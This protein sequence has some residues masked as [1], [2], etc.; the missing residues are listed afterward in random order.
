MGQVLHTVAVLGHVHWARARLSRSLQTVA[1]GGPGHEVLA[2]FARGISRGSPTIPDEANRSVAHGCRGH[3]IRRD[4]QCSR[5]DRWGP[6][7]VVHARSLEL[8]TASR[9]HQPSR[10]VCR[11]DGVNRRTEGAV[12]THWCERPSPSRRQPS[13]D[14]HREQLCLRKSPHDAGTPQAEDSTGRDG[15]TDP[16]R[17]ASVRHEQVRGWVVETIPVWRPPDPAAA[18]AFRSGWNEGAVRRFSVSTPRRASVL[19]THGD[20]SGD[21]LPL[22]QGRSAA[23]VPA[24][25]PD[26]RSRIEAQDDASPGDLVDTGLAAP[27]MASSSAA[28]SQSGRAA[29]STTT[30]GLVGAAE[31]EPSM[32]PADGRSQPVTTRGRRRMQLSATGVAH[33]ERIA[34]PTP[35]ASQAAQL[36]AEYAW[37]ERTKA[38]RNQQWKTWLYFCDE[39][40]RPPLTVTEAHFVSFLGWL[41]LERQRGGRQIGSTSVPQYMSAVR[42]MQLTLTGV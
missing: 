31:L 9:V 39:D 17:M 6:W 38:T 7:N 8:A 1:S 5:L 25:G 41:M 4:T 15:G 2:G 32:A 14:A 24:C 42:Q 23:T 40:G 21:G 19:P 33:V 16:S 30:R 13:R 26:W 10:I 27:T 34:G 12:A 3:G 11:A 18:V 35:G 28:T 22:G 37:S 29:G 36:V 20:V